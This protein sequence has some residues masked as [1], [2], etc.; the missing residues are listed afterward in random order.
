MSAGDAEG[1]QQYKDMTGDP[2]YDYVKSEVLEG[3]ELLGGFVYEPMKMAVDEPR[4]QLCVAVYDGEE[5][6]VIEY[7]LNYNKLKRELEHASK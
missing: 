4:K 6:G 7:K 5:K 2:V 1:K 3:G